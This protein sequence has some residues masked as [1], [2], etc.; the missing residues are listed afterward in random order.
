MKLS[1]VIEAVDKASTRIKRITGN[2]RDLGTRGM[3]VVQRA[4]Q[5]ANRE[6]G[7]FGSG[8]PGRLKA[9]TVS[10]T[11]FAGR[12]GLK[13][14][15]KSAYGAGYAIGWLVRKGAG[16]ALAAAKWAAA[17]ATFAAGWSIGNIIR[18]ASQ[19]EQFQVIL[20]NTEGSAD[21]ARKAMDWVK[22]FAKT[23]PYEVGAVM[24]AFVQLRAYGIDP[25]DGSMRA[26]GNMASG[27][28]KEIMQA[29][30]M[31]ADAQTGEFERLKEFGIK[32]SQKGGQVTLTY[33]KN[34]KE[35][36]KSM[37]QNATAIRKALIAIAD[38]R[39]AGMMDRQSR[40]LKGM[41][42]N[43]MDMV[44]NFELDVANAGFFDVVKGKVQQLLNW[45]NKL[46]AD[47]TL[48]KWAQ[49]VSGWLVEMTNKATDFIQ[50]TDW[51]EVGEDLKIIGRGAW[52]IALAIGKAVEWASKLSAMLNDLPPWIRIAMPGE[53]IKQ[54]IGVAGGVA[55]WAW[56]SKSKPPASGQSSSRAQIPNSPLKNRNA[57]PII[58]PSRGTAA[59]VKGEVTV[60]VE[61]APGTRARVTG[62]SASPNLS[63]NASNRGRA[64]EAPA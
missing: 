12:M 62:A 48:A 59:P 5:G 15:E 58:W 3:G 17:G 4:T 14:I 9:M 34:G 55:S 49:K 51:K 7:R 31:L 30:E 45:V 25:M 56:G 28:N 61:A 19:F 33:L 38:D 24:E 39:F 60:K 29:V 52:S 26:L 41:W 6:L 18:T 20:E 40:T 64:M 10:A 46:A 47:G 22:A 16:L 13:A 23:T 32:A 27:M 57:A 53:N 11:R 21:K 43:I 42:S 1:L 54:G 44:S 36:R 8:I 37:A 63:L 2:V 35:I 50:K